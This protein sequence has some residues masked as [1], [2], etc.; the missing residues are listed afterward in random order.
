MVTKCDYKLSSDFPNKV[1]TETLI[2]M[3]YFHEIQIQMALN[4]KKSINY[5]FFSY[6]ESKFYF[7]NITMLNLPLI[8]SVKHNESPFFMTF[9]RYYS[10]D[11]NDGCCSF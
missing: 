7:G 4:F 10:I 2:V 11:C 9:F 6:T 8:S 1:K 5:T 3:Y